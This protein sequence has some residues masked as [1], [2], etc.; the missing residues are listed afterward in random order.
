MPSAELKLWPRIERRRH[1]RP[2]F[3][4]LGGIEEQ[5]LAE[6]AGDQLHAHRQPLDD[7]GR[8]RNPG[9]TETGGRRLRPLRRHEAIVEPEW[10]EM[11]RKQA[12]A[13][14]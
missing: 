11:R 8:H 10:T 13:I 12:A 5:I 2:R 4:D 3:D 6:A 9:Q 7:A 1:R 14:E